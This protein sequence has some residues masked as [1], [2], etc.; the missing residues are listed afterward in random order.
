MTKASD[1]VYPKVLLDMQ[2]SSPA[3]PSDAT[4][5]LHAKADGIYARSSNTTVGPFGTATGELVATSVI[6]DAAGDLVQGT[7]ANT[8]TR[9]AIG[10][11]A[12]GLISTGSAAAWAEILPWHVSIIP[13]VWTP[14]AT[15]G[16][17]V[18]GQNSATTAAV[19]PFEN[20]G[21]TAN[22]GTANH[23]TN[24][25]TAAINDACAWDVVLAAGTWD[26]HFWSLD[27]SSSGIITL[28]QDGAS[29]GTTDCYAATANYVKHSITGWTVAATGKK[30][31]QV[32]MAT[33]NGSSSNYAARLLAIEFRR[34][35]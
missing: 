26:A 11:A 27:A 4:W 7:G 17:W 22:S 14:D 2:T 21:S 15:T 31:M 35:A 1:N 20:P 13:M 25:A 29:Q 23:W 10:T 19:A 16:T 8:G 34:T 33:K 18:I 3:A 24:S 6:W 28:N 5:K 30:R 12:Y 32:L 9:L